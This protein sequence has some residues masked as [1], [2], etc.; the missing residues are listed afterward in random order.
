[1]KRS[2]DRECC[3]LPDPPVHPGVPR[4]VGGAGVVCAGASELGCPVLD[5]G[6]ADD[7]G[8]L[9]DELGAVVVVGAVDDVLGGV[10][11]VLGAS[12]VDDTDGGGTCCDGRSVGRPTTAPRD[13]PSL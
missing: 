11:V 1:M 2:P 13:V 10:V 5:G 12:G 8:E 7:D 3:H 4:P 9:L 6:V